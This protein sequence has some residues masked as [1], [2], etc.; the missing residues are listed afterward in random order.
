MTNVQPSIDLDRLRHIIGS[1]SEGVI[2]VDANQAII[3][4]NEAALRMHGVDDLSGLGKDVD[5]YRER[6]QLR[7]RNKHRLGEGDYPIDRVIAGEAFDEVVVEVI[8]RDE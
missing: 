1:L 7:Y 6:F 4:A 3:W 5:D 2:L 8:P